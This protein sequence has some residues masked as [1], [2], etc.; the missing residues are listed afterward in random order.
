MTHRRTLLIGLAASFCAGPAFAGPRFKP[1]FD[2]RSLAGWN[3]VGDA[4]WGVTDGAIVA[5]TGAV[6]FLVS[7]DS[8]RDFDLRAEFWVSADANSGIFIRCSDRTG[9][10]SANAYEVNIFDTR[11]DP[12]YGTGAIVDVAKVSPMP[13]AGGQWNTMLIEARGDRFTVR[14]N[15]RKTVDA[16]RD[17]KHAAGPIALQYGAGVVKFRKIE[18][19]PL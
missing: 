17:G 9:I 5:D 12:T 7:R 18:I 10:T 4:N 11:P 8:Y 19:R 2:G 1:L 6:S 15:D 13:K 3:P 14:F 16:A